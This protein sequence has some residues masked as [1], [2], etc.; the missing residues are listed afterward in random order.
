MLTSSSKTWTICSMKMRMKLLTRKQMRIRMKKILKPCRWNKECRSKQEFNHKL[1]ILQVSLMT[2]GLSSKWE[3]P[4]ILNLKTLLRLWVC[5]IQGQASTKR[6]N[7]S[8]YLS[9]IRF[10]LILYILFSLLQNIRRQQRQ[11]NWQKGP[12]NYHEDAVWVEA[13]LKGY[14]NPRWQDIQWGHCFIRWEGIPWP[15][16]RPEDFMEHKYWT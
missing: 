8:I 2:Q 14:E 4:D 13:W 15:R 9:L 16:R 12:W 7:V 6:S 10:G 5:L 1:K 11:E 3:Q